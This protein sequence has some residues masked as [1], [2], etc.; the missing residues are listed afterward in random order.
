MNI[1]N[2]LKQILDNQNQIIERLDGLEKKISLISG[3]KDRREKESLTKI[4]GLS[5]IKNGKYYHAVRTIDGSTIRIYIGKSKDRNI[6]KQKIAD[7]LSYNSWA[8]D[9]LEKITNVGEI[10]NYAVSDL[11]TS[12]SKT[13]PGNEC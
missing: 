5:I 7:W 13:S 2:I 9:S 12:S 4:W 1:N 11:S 10:E 3:G 6:V 8:K